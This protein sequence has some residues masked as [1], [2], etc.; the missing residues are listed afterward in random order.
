MWP[1]TLSPRYESEEEDR[2]VQTVFQSRELGSQKK[3]HS[4]AKRG[5]ELSVPS[6]SSSSSEGKAAIRD[7]YQKTL[8][9]SPTFKN[10]DLNVSQSDID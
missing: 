5:N 4:S 7:P 6:D 2:E 1:K 8:F 3:W 10:D 9:C